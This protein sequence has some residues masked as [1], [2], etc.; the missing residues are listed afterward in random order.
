MRRRAA[1]MLK[2]QSAYTCIVKGYDEPPQ[3]IGNLRLRI[4]IAQ[5]AA[6][7]G[8]SNG[9]LGSYLEVTLAR[10]WAAAILTAEPCEPRVERGEYAEPH[11]AP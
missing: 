11:Q 7:P 3:Q 5:D 9:S 10:K 1:V 2:Q 8:S 4:S 6:S